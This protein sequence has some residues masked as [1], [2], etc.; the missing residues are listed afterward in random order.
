M[1]G[2]GKQVISREQRALCVVCQAESVEC[3]TLQRL[4]VLRQAT[5]QKTVGFEQKDTL[6]RQLY[7]FK[8]G[9]ELKGEQ[10]KAH[11]LTSPAVHTQLLG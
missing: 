4:S 9:S 5:L 1:Q 3:T 8:V 2:K 10:K 6:F 7:K 11:C